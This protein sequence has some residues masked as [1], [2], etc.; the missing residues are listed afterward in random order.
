MGDIPQ[1][2]ELVQVRFSDWIESA[3]SRGH[4]VQIVHSWV[5]LG[6]HGAFGG[7]ISYAS[8]IDWNHTGDVLGLVIDF[9]DA[10]EQAGME[11]LARVMLN[12]SKEIAPIEEIRIQRAK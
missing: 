8:A 12:I 7:H 1:G 2:A 9:G 4:I 6:L 5:L 11:L 10:D 3:S